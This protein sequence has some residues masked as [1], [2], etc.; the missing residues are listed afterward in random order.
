MKKLSALVLTIV[1]AWTGATAQQDPM[2]THYMFNSI[3]FNPAYAGS[4]DH[5]SL[6][7]LH[8]SQWVGLD[9]APTTQWLFAHSPL[10]N[11]RVGVGAAF[12]NDQ[13]GPIGVSEG[14]LSYAYRIPFGKN[15]KLAVGLQGGVT[16]WRSDWTKL[17]IK[18][19]NDGVFEAQPA[20]WLP[21]FGAGLYLSN[22][23][24]YV[25]FA[26]PKLV[27][28]D[29]RDV[30]TPATAINAKTYRHYYASIGAAI[31]LG[32]EKLIFKPSALVKS[33]SWFSSA[34]KDNNY[35]NIGA[36]TEANLDISFFLQETLWIGSSFRTSL[37]KFDG[38]R[39]SFDSVDFWMQYYL[40]N[41]LRLGAAYDYSLT[42]LQTVSAGSFEV[43]IG[44]E[45]DYKTKKVVTPRY[46]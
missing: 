41:G 10:K 27:E 19:G 5:L 6:G 4:N 42:P 7:L 40:Q 24:F 9:G 22:K 11:E 16:N 17:K 36:P 33:V 45:F 12:A 23:K 44:Y 14:Y 32:S 15:W 18:E 29:L 39:S 2:V 13:I 31:P 20:K 35:D 3:A 34:R 46:F 25:G 28:Y 37:E 38:D 21:N 26:S 1:F 30:N 43:L 8:R